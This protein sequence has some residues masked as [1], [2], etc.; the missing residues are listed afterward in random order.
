WVE[1]MRV[2]IDAVRATGKLCEAAICYTGDLL[3]PRRPKYDLKYYVSLAKELEA[4]GA[5]ILGIKDMAGLCQPEA[6]RRLVTALKNGIS[7]PIHF[8]TH[9]TS[10][11]AG[12]SVLAAV[13]AGADAVDAAMDSMSGLTSHPN[14]GSI[15]EALRHTERD[16]GLNPDAI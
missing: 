10:G 7:L 6:A 2:A 5:H 3:D 8:H 14:L 16:S 1:N 4:A 15:V 9:D 13:E 12:A 11:I